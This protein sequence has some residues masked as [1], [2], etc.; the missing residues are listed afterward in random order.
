MRIAVFGASGSTGREVVDQALAKGHEVSV[1]VRDPAAY[2]VRHDRL[3]V[4]VGDIGQAQSVEDVVRGQDSV[5]SALG[6]TKRGPVTVCSD[7][8]K[9]I[10]TAMEKHDLRRLL[11]V[12]VYGAGSSR[13][14]SLFV[15]LTRAMLGKN[16]LDKDRMEELIH[17]SS[18]DWTIVRPPRLTAGPRSG[19]YRAGTDVRVGLTSHISRADLAEFLVRE[20]ES[21][22]HVHETPT[23]VSVRQTG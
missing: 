14:R 13:D 2:N 18:L 8:A 11:A 23:I 5:I 15:I 12:S 6:S 21:G 9:A 7:G 20:A 16:M 19:A 4:V 1:L 22:A 10:M 17:A 3:E